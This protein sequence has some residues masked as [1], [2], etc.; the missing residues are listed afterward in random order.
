LLV[1]KTQR[2]RRTFR[3]PLD[4]PFGPF[5]WP[6]L[7]RPRLPL[8]RGASEWAWFDRRCSIVREYRFSC[9]KVSERV[10]ERRP[11]PPPSPPHGRPESTWEATAK[12][13]SSPGKA[14]TPSRG[15]QGTQ[16]TRGTRPSRP[17]QRSARGRRARRVHGFGIATVVRAH[18]ADAR[19]LSAAPPFAGCP[20]LEL[21]TC[22]STSQRASKA[23]QATTRPI[24]SWLVGRL[25]AGSHSTAS[26]SLL[27]THRHTF[28]I[29]I[30]YIVDSAVGVEF[31]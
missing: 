21:H 7:L 20:S 6:L 12:Q 10:S 16:G 17:E 25:A 9:S 28:Y 11:R 8:F 1:P 14:L 3:F 22:I 26:A 31:V 5:P 23:P 19:A 18:I 29:Y 30:G 4:D 24:P 2:P 27:P 13:G 15:T